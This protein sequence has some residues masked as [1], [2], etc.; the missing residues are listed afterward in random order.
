MFCDTR[1]ALWQ[2]PPRSPDL[3]PVERFW[4]WLRRKLRAMDLKDVVAKHPVLGKI[5]YKSRVRIYVFFAA[6]AASSRGTRGLKKVCMEAFRN[7]GAA[8][9]G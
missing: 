1:V 8:T 3:N 9:S 4:A 5:A 7:E 2:I 6:G